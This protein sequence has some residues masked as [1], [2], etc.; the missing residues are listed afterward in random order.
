MRTKEKLNKK[1]KRAKEIMLQTPGFHK[2][3]YESWASA[4]RRYAEARERQRERERQAYEND[5]ER[6]KNI[7]SVVSLGYLL[8]VVEKSCWR[9]GCEKKRREKIYLSREREDSRPFLGMYLEGQRIASAFENLRKKT[10]V[11]ICSEV[12]TTAESLLAVL[13]RRA[14]AMALQERKDQA[15]PSFF[16]SLEEVLFQR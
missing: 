1:R 13:T 6:K 4:E 5:Q 8:R 12:D 9:M 14:N 11:E 2:G 10:A 15:T 3:Y 7:L 16:E